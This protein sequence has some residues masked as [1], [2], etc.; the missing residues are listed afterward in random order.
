MLSPVV[1]LHPEG[2][3]VAE[4]GPE[5][6]EHFLGPLLRTVAPSS[7]PLVRTPG[8]PKSEK[9]VPVDLLDVEDAVGVIQKQALG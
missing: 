5:V 1:E 2:A 8:I 9:L 4:L 3:V 7:I 6:R